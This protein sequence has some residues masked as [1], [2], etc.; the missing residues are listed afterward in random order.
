MVAATVSTNLGIQQLPVCFCG[1]LCHCEHGECMCLLGCD[2]AEVMV[3]E[4]CFCRAM[5]I[6]VATAAFTVPACI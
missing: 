2:V 1:D 3:G 6:V 4:Q 5:G